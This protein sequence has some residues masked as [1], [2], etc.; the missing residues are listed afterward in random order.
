LYSSDQGRECEEAAEQWAA[1]AEHKT[2]SG[3]NVAKLSEQM[4]GRLAELTETL[5]A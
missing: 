1:D 3:T 5:A 2:N 4:E